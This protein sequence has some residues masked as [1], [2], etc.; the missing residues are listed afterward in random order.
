MDY[1]EER[2]ERKRKSKE[3]LKGACSTLFNAGITLVEVHY[4]GYGDSGEIEY[5]LFFKGDKQLTDDEVA[6]LGLPT[7]TTEEYNHNHKEGESLYKT[8]EC[9]LLK[10]VEDCAY[11][12]LP[13]GWEINEGSFGDLKINTEKAKVTR[14]HNFRIEETEYSEEDYEL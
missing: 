6:S 7:S 11:D 8:V 13:G 1:F 2:E 9:T 5:V 12:F 10:K 4:D 14:E 3:S